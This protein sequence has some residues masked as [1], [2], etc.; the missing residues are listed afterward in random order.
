MY[1]AEIWSTTAKSNIKIVEQLQSTYL[2]R[3]LDAPLYMRKTQI[4][5]ETNTEPITERIQSMKNKLQEKLKDH[6]NA[7][8]RNLTI[9]P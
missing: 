7:E 9:V 5:R 6:P 1:G 4:Q 2:R 8:L 3:A